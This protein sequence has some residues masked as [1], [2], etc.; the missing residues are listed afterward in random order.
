MFNH[1]NISIN[2]LLYKYIEIIFQLY[3]NKYSHNLEF[4]KILLIHETGFPSN[5]CFK[6]GCRWLTERK[7]ESSIVL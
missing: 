2:F 6:N 7:L 3:N 5:R 4:M 1:S